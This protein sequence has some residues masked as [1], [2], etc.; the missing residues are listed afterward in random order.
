MTNKRKN[1]MPMIVVITLVVIGLITALVVLNSQNKSSVESDNHKISESPSI[2][3]HPTIGEDDAPVQIIEFGDYKCPSCKAWSERVYPQLKK[4]FID[5]GKVNLT[6]INTLFHGEES[7]LAAKAGEAVYKQNPEAF[8]DFHKKLFEA[9]PNQKHD[10]KWV[11]E[12]KVLEIA[13][14]S[15]PS[16]ELTQMREDLHSGA[17][18][19]EVQNDM[20]LVNEYGIQQT[21]T[22]MIDGQIVENP[23][24]YEAISNLINQKLENKNG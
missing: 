7:E 18:A 20:D 13:E 2:K 6:Y 14:E 9:Q 1:R 17:I 22:I 15:V 10:Q 21:P 24:D 11:T 23:F 8:W 5:T 3:N 19:Q 16:I 4:E 12:D